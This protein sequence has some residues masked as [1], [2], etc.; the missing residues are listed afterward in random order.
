MRS[1]KSRKASAKLFYVENASPVF[2]EEVPREI[3][4]KVSFDENNQLMESKE[5]K[6]TSPILLGEEGLKLSMKVSGL[7]RASFFRVF[8]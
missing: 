4:V 7:E 5:F 3:I 6:Y 2:K 8:P 1:T